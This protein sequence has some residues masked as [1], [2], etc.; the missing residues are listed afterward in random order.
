MGKKKET[1]Q[2]HLAKTQKFM[3]NFMVPEMEMW[4]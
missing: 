1:W 2:I 3:A 4:G